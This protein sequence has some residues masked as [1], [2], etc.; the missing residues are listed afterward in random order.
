MPNDL[1]TKHT[2]DS[3]DNSTRDHIRLIVSS[4]GD[5]RPNVVE[6]L[7]CATATGAEEKPFGNKIAI[8]FISQHTGAHQIECR[9]DFPGL[10]LEDLE[11]HG[12]V[13]G[14]EPKLID[15]EKEREHT[16]RASGVLS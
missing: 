4:R 10:T 9:L 7:D 13:N 14:G 15:S 6:V 8:E 1:K 12:S 5:G 11:L 3:D 2:L 16:W